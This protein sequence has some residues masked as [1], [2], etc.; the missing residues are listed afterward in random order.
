M[1]IGLAKTPACL[2][3]ASE[4]AVWTLTRQS[5]IRPEAGLGGVGREPS[6]RSGEPQRPTV[7]DV[8]L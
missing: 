6:A 3:I 7:E 5:N 1:A 4:Y 2:A 8:V